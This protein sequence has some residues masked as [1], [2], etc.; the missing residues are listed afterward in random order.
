VRLPSKQNRESIY[1]EAAIAIA[2]KEQE[3]MALYGGRPWTVTARV[4]EPKNSLKPPLFRWYRGELELAVLP[5]LLEKIPEPP[6]LKGNQEYTEEEEYVPSTS[7]EERT[8]SSLSWV[9]WE[10]REY[11]IPNVTVKWLSPDHVYFYSR[12]SAWEHQHNLAEQQLFLQKMMD[13][14]GHRGQ[15]LKPFKPS[16]NDAM[17]A[18]KW[19]FLRDGLWVVGQ[20]ESWQEQRVEWWEEELGRKAAAQAALEAKKEAAKASSEADKKPAAKR[21][22]T[23]LSYYLQS[24]RHRYREEKIQERKLVQGDSTEPAGMTLREAETEL[25]D[26]W[27]TLPSKEQNEWKER[28]KELVLQQAGNVSMDG[29]TVVAPKA[30]SITPTESDG[31]GAAAQILDGNYV[32]AGNSAKESAHAP[33]SPSP[34]LAPPSP[35][36]TP[37]DEDEKQT[38]SIALLTG[39]KVMSESSGV[40]LPYKKCS[41]ASENQQVASK[42]LIS[43]SHVLSEPE[44]VVNASLAANELQAGSF[45]P[46][47]VAISVQKTTTKALEPRSEVL[48]ESEASIDASLSETEAKV[49][50]SAAKS[51]NH[52]EK[53]PPMTMGPANQVLSESGALP[54]GSLTTGEAQSRCYA[55]VKEETDTRETKCMSVKPGSSLAASSAKKRRKLASRIPKKITPSSHFRM[56]PEQIEMCHNAVMN[57]FEL[58]MNTVKARALYSELQDGFDVLRERGRGRY[59]MELPV[60]DNPKFSFLTDLQQ[61]AWMPIVRE[62]LGEDVILIHKGAFLSMPGAETQ[63]Y[64]QDGPHISTHSQRPCHAV[65]VF[66]PL[67]DLHKRNGPTEFCLGTHILG[68]EGYVKDRVFAP[69]VPA[70]TP[71]MFDYRLGHL[72]KSNASSAC[73]PIVYCTYAAA[74]NGKEFRDSVNFSRRR[75]HKIGD[76]VEK[77][78]SRAERAAKRRKSQSDATPALP[79][80]QHEAKK[81]AEMPI[82]VGASEQVTSTSRNERSAA[83]LEG[84]LE[85][86]TSPIERET[87]PSVPIE[88]TVSAPAS[89]AKQVAASIESVQPPSLVATAPSELYFQAPSYGYGALESLRDQYPGRFSYSQPPFPAVPYQSSQQVFGVVPDAAFAQGQHPYPSDGADPYARFSQMQFFHGLATQL[90]RPHVSSF[91]SGSEGTT[92]H[93]STKNRGG[94]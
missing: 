91:P 59:D 46:S 33:V 88:P 36:F 20:E 77:P 80:S 13:G 79:E 61:A 37:M 94:K 40:P 47:T 31:K 82:P 86:A 26:V 45:V 85:L 69:C 2:N 5:H 78:L 42:T 35:T 76:L 84:E 27:K 65:N 93:G 24:E 71:V 29:N 12:K 63:E 6:K 25:R 90:Q 66:I 92:S 4:T 3:C 83:A 57:H 38:G 50:T 87:A 34:P 68:H 21:C 23:G 52:K 11:A 51:A 54:S 8:V 15:K 73:R 62:V 70:G 74:A 48:S 41:E 32:V 1:K 14:L 58:V 55:H 72:G 30:S 44:V 43:G 39:A 49:C 64:H 7:L 9:A 17:K 60:F 81:L 16:K 18:G 28:A 53:A 19:R 10:A 67:V 56:T 22:M 89:E 75:Y